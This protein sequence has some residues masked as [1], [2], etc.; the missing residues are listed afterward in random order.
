MVGLHR[1]A[2]SLAVAAAATSL[3]VL[4]ATPAS[5][6]ATAG[7]AATDWRSRVTGIDPA[8]TALTAR[9]TDL[10]QHLEITVRPGHR[11]VVL[12]YSAEP[13]VRVDAS[14][15]WVNRRSPAEYL[16]RAST[17]PGTLPSGFDARATPKWQR[18][19]DGWTYRWHD[20]RVHHMAGTTVAVGGND[21]QIPVLV[22]DQAAM[23]T[24]RLDHVDGPNAAV[25][26]FGVVVGVGIV[27]AACSRLAVQRRRS[28]AAITFA[29]LAAANVVQMVGVWQASTD[30]FGGRI[31][32]ALYALAAA[33]ACGLLTRT[34]LRADPERRAPLLLLCG[35]VVSI[36]G[37]VANAGW[38]FH[39]QLPTTMPGVIARAIVG[40]DLVTGLS[41]VVVGVRLVA[42]RPVDAES[43]LDGG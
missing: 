33:F 1:F 29:L 22:D 25:V 28:A 5:A 26:V 41:A 15:I 20:H 8:S 32:A 37:G 2:R 6:H 18:I 42:R 35:V 11:V 36:C 27:V 3:I 12:G 40:V 43:V 16:N 21:W 19:A 23:I 30:P 24:G 39:S 4:G 38:L 7:Q 17:L 10:G 13:Y 31:G 9:T 34:L 14:G